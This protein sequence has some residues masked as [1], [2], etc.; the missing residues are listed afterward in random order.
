MKKLCCK[1]LYF[2]KSDYKLNRLTLQI[3]DPEIQKYYDNFR[4]QNYKDLAIPTF[5]L[6]AG[7]FIF[8]AIM[9]LIAG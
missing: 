2:R 7:H 9:M 4:Q 1:M 6:A 5:V 8:R 3:S